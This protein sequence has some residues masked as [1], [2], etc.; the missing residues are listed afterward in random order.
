MVKTYASNKIKKF[1]LFSKTVVFPENA[2][3]KSW[4][5]FD[6]E[7]TLVVT[8]PIDNIILWAAS[9]G[10]STSEKILKRTLKR[11]GWQHDM[12]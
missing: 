1:A 5:C 7:K 10:E 8:R 9:A 6:P 11:R 4:G 12:K 3:T 2:Q